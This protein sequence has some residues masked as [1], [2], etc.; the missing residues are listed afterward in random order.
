MS[1]LK[2][3]VERDVVYSRPLGYW[4]SAP[5][6]KKG[7]VVRLLPLLV[8]RRPLELKMDIYLP[9]DDGVA[10]RPL[11]LMMHGGSFFVGNKNEKGQALWCEHFASLGYVAAS[12][13][14]RLGFRPTRKDFSAAEDRALEDAD[15][16]LA[17]LLRRKDLRIDPD[18][19]FAAGTSAGAMLALRLAFRRGGPRFRAIANCWGAVHDL[20]ILGYADTAI[21]SF[22]SPSDPVMPY[23]RGYPFRTGNGGPRLPSQWVSRE[24]FGTGAIHQR[25]LE[26]GLR[27][28]HHRFPEP[29][30]RLH[31][32]DA[33]NCT[34]RFF[35]IRDRM[36]AFF[37][38]YL[39]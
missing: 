20:G 29:R 21:L 1:L 17:Y 30:H 16:A 5:V 10:R 2:V 25:A 18:C 39:H 14:Y 13:D 35:E 6:G 8:Q 7:T 26:L 27:A 33:G 28:E 4:A 31:L 23:G 9:E 38:P 19:L 22:Q 11:L 15:A 34:P 3:T 12:V 32:D 24:M 36:E 37:H